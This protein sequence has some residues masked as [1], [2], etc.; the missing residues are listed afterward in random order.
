MSA[1]T[2]GA[3]LFQVIDVVCHQLLPRTPVAKVLEFYVSLN[4]TTVGDEDE[5][6]DSEDFTNKRIVRQTIPSLVPR[7]AVDAVR[8]ATR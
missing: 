8:R 7:C 1:K 2:Q 3:G 4:L 5:I 6:E